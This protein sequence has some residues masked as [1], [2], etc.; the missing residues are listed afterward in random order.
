MP[1][2]GTKNIPEVASYAL[3]TFVNILS[4]RIV[5]CT[6]SVTPWDKSAVKA[7]TWFACPT[8]I[9][10]NNLNILHYGNS[11]THQFTYDFLVGFVLH[12][13]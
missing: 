4:Y 10:K 2:T 9:Q 7:I 5:C 12:N 8:K 13:L 11:R 3:P 1:D 6:P